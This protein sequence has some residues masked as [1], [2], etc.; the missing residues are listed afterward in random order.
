MGFMAILPYVIEGIRSTQNPV[1][2]I[3]GSKIIKTSR[4]LIHLSHFH[5]SDSITI[6]KK[7]ISEY[8]TIGVTCV[9][10]FWL[11]DLQL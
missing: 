6:R 4:F 2:V 11:L 5:Y 3:A 10:Y 7:Y 9:A 1:H 8:R